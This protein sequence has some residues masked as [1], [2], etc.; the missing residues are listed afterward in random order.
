MF[1]RDDATMSAA[2]MAI[3]IVL[4]AASLVALAMLLYAPLLRR[5]EGALG[6]RTPM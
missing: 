2:Q 3:M 1:V 4:G 5:R 6:R